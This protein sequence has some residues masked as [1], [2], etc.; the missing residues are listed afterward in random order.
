MLPLKVVCEILTS[1]QWNDFLLHKSLIKIG[2]LFETEE[3]KTLED[4]ATEIDRE[5]QQWERTGKAGDSRFIEVITRMLEWFDNQRGDRE[6]ER[7]FIYFYTNRAQLLLKTLNDNNVSGE[8]FAILSHRE[9]LPTLVKLAE[10]PDLSEK[11]LADFADNPAQFKEFQVLR[12]QISSQDL[13]EIIDNQQEFQAFR[14]LTEEVSFKEISELVE[15]KDKFDALKHLSKLLQDSADSGATSEL[16][17]ALQ[18]L[19]V[20]ETVASIF[21]STSTGQVRDMPEITIDK[22]DMAAIG[23]KGEEFVY[24]KLVK[25]F[26]EERVRWLNKDCEQFGPYDFV[27]T[28]SNGEE[29]IYIDAKATS[30]QESSADRIPFYVGSSEWAFSTNSDRYY[31]ARVFRIRTAPTVK[32][33]KF[34][35][36]LND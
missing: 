16:I 36:L 22:D 3:T 6:I 13:K 1:N 10:N 15:N 27:V 31:L 33:L 8:V 18:E 24:Q 25:K 34:V 21:L 19:G 4:I 14:I 2:E 35:R 7:L 5:I 12:G 30:T 29:D 28:G 20:Y 26:G 23:R 9:K 32:F 17:I 11:D